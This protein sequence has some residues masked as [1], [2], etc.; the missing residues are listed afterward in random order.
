MTKPFV[1][2]L[3]LVAECIEKHSASRRMN[4]LATKV[5]LNDQILAAPQ[6]DTSDVDDAQPVLEARRRANHVDCALV[7]AGATQPCVK[8]NTLGHSL[9]DRNWKSQVL[10]YASATDVRRVV[11]MKGREYRIHDTSDDVA[12]A[13][14]SFARRHRVASSV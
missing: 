2:A 1:A 5:S 9:N 3:R 6:W 12:V 8:A 4:E 11:A 13:G 10:S 7:E 14:E